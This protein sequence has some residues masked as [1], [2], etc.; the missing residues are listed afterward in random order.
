LIAWT[1][2][3]ERDQNNRTLEMVAAFRIAQA[4]EKD[5]LRGLRLLAAGR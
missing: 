1:D 3:F 4:E 2:L 5:Y